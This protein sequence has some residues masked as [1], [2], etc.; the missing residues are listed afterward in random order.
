MKSKSH[1]CSNILFHL[2]LTIAIGLSAATCHAF[3]PDTYS[4]SSVLASGRWVKI[5]VSTTG[6]HLI[7]A[8]HAAPVG[9]HL[10]RQSA[11]LRLRRQSATRRPHRRKLYRRSARS[12]VGDH[13]ART[14]V[15]RPWPRDMDRI[16]DTQITLAQP[17]FGCRLLLPDRS[18]RTRASPGS[19][20]GRSSIRAADH[21]H[22]RP[23][24]RGRLS[25]A[26]SHRSPDVR[27]RFRLHAY[28]H[29]RFPAY[30]QHRIRVGKR[31][32]LV[33]DQ[34]PLVGLVAHVHSQRPAAPVIVDRPH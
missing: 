16:G 12:T 34:N 29:F 13:I 24:S 19:R 20:H 28:S 10:T 9:I 2:I 5:S 3:A 26:R 1:F 14:G 33:R 7:P 25:V 8:G 17:L 18:R 30:R 21:V 27:R 31:G 22:L 4:A 23:L 6:M 32:L 15:L 11:C